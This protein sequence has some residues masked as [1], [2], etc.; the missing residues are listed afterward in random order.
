MLA[1]TFL[2]TVISDLAACHPVSHYWQVVP[3]PGPQCRQGYA[4]LLTTGILNILTNLALVLFPIPM[5]LKARLPS[6]Q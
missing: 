3:D 5:I 2:A 6:T 1:V 4:H